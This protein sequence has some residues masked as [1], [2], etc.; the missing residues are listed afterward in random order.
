MLRGSTKWF[1]SYVESCLCVWMLLLLKSPLNPGK[2]F[3]N[4][5]YNAGTKHTL[6]SNRTATASKSCNLQGKH[7]LIWWTR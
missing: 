3:L 1:T 2:S 5:R 7:L 4:S 6:V